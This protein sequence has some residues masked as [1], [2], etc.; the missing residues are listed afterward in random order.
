MFPLL[1]MNNYP[2][3]WTDILNF[4]AQHLLKLL[5]P[6][7]SKKHRNKVCFFNLKENVKDISIQSL[8]VMSMH[9]LAQV[10]KE[11]LFN[12]GL[13]LFHKIFAGFSGLMFAF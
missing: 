13:Y 10:S 2:F 7:L 12:S 1:I 8:L 4:E 5:H 6:L 3:F 11:T 9:K